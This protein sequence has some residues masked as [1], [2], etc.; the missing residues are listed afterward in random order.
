MCCFKG[1]W[2]AQNFFPR[3]AWVW[4]VHLQ[5]VQV[6]IRFHQFLSMKITTWL[7]QQKKKR[8]FYH[9]TRQVWACGRFWNSLWTCQDSVD[10]AHWLWCK[11]HGWESLAR[12][13]IPP[14]K[15]RWLAASHSQLP[16]MSWFIIPTY[17]SAPNLGVAIAIDPFTRVY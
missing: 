4:Y 14:G 6:V 16:W 10:V 12:G 15:D 3:F 13:F 9:Q 7:P 17:K 8:R 1:G 2:V 11:A 5:V